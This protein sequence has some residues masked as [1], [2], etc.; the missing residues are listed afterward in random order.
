[1]PTLVL[2][3]GLAGAGKST[4]AKAISQSL[5]FPVL[6]KDDIGDHLFPT[7]GEHSKVNPVCY[8]ILWAIVR[9]QLNLGISVVADSPLRYMSD[10]LTVAAWARQSNATVR[11]IRVTCSDSALWAKRLEMRNATMPPHRTMNWA[12]HQRWYA[13][14]DGIEPVEGE[15]EIDSAADYGANLDKALRYIQAPLKNTWCWK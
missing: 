11:P 1:M 5:G 6:D 10:F 7:L 13:E 9:T 15:C 4:Y 2:M 8:Q 14:T 12:E 3:R